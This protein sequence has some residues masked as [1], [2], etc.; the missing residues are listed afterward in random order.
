MQIEEADLLQ[1][2]KCL[3][4]KKFKEYLISSAKSKK[5]TTELFSDRGRKKQTPF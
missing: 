1:Y 3:F 4:G 2:N 5:Q